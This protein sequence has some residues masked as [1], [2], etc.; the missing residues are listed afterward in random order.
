M[1]VIDRDSEMMDVRKADKGTLVAQGRGLG[2]V[3]LNINSHCPAPS[4]Y[5]QDF[6]SDVQEFC[7]DVVNWIEPEGLEKCKHMYCDE[8]MNECRTHN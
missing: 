8:Y 7:R 3:E 4:P 6:D 5:P 2:K 1:K